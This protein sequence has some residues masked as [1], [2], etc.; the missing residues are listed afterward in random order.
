VTISAP[1]FFLGKYSWRNSCQ[2]DTGWVFKVRQW[3]F[4]LSWTPQVAE[5]ND[6]CYPAWFDNVTISFMWK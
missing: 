6:L 1:G 5:I 2:M 3:I 4:G